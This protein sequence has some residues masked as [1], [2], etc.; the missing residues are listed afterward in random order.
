VHG[1]I[2]PQNIIIQSNNNDLTMKLIDLGST[3]KKDTTKRFSGTSF[4]HH[5]DHFCKLDFSAD[6]YRMGLAGGYLF[7]EYFIFK[8]H[9]VKYINYLELKESHVEP[10]SEFE[11]AIRLLVMLLIHDKRLRRPTCITEIEYV[12]QIIANSETLTTLIAAQI[13]ASTIQRHETTVEDV[14]RGVRCK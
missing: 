9:K 3:H 8:E 2:K 5:P 14:L 11:K 13:A 1:D 10:A 12:S 7:R 6:M 4:F